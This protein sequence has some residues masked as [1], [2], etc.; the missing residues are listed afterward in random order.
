MIDGV[1]RA[2]LDLLVEDGRRTMTEIADRVGLSPSA[3]KRRVDRLERVG[4]ISGCTVLLDHGK[5]GTSL[6]AFVELRFA[7]DVKVETIAMA[8]A[9][10]AEAQEV[11]TVAGDPDALVRVRVANVQHLRDVIDRLRRTGAVIG[12]KTL[13]VLGTW[14]RGAD[15]GSTPDRLRARRSARLVA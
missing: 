7:G 4:V 2:I 12:T 10:V 11:F 13:M 1:D 14:R 3:V 15:S 5:L 8:A 6:E 9:S